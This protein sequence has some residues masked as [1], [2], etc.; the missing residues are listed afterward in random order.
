MSNQQNIRFA[1]SLVKMN[2]LTETSG[3]FIVLCE[4]SHGCPPN[5]AT[6]SF[7]LS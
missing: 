2:R 1:Q 4:I 6:S 5:P 3:L 7:R